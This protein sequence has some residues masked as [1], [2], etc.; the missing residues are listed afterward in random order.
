MSQLVPDNRGLPPVLI[1]LARFLT[2]IKRPG[3]ART[4]PAADRQ[5][6]E[7]V[8]IT[9]ERAATT[10]RVATRHPGWAVRLTQLSGSSAGCRMRQLRMPGAVI[11]PALFRIMVTV[12]ADYR[13]RVCGVAQP[14]AVRAICRGIDL[15]G[16]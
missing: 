12:G 1:R 14:E 13:L 16:G 15:P 10:A 9:K 2:G 4:D 3:A 5:V 6:A 8:A 7:A 11:V